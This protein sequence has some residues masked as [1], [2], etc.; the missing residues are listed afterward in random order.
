V[1]NYSELKKSAED[2]KNWKN[3]ARVRNEMKWKCND[4]VLESRLR[5]GL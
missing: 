3:L 4:C 1:E 5:A 2:R